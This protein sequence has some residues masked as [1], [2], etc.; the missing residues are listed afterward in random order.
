ARCRLGDVEVAAGGVQAGG[1]A[2][3][4]GVEP[5]CPEFADAADIG[6]VLVFFP[7]LILPSAL[8]LAVVGDV[9]QL[10]ADLRV[11]L[12]QRFEHTGHG[13]VL[14]MRLPGGC[15]RLLPSPEQCGQIQQY[16]PG[17]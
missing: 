17:V 9:A 7:G 15:E 1:A 13:P 8:K 12:G 6:T 11:A 3:C 5:G 10:S 2:L 4:L 14:A 16:A